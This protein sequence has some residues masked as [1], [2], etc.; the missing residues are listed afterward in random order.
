L[1]PASTT[2]AP[3]KISGWF[4]YALATLAAGVLAAGFAVV[5]RLALYHGV[6]LVTGHADILAGFSSLPVPLR[7]VLPAL[8]GLCAAALGLVAA[9]RPGGH[10]I[11]EILE[12]VAL[13]RGQIHLLTVVWKGAAS[14]VALVTGGS[15]GR[16]G[17][18]IQFGAGAGA[19]LG[20]N[21]GLADRE[22]RLL[23]A[24]GTAA[25]FAA[26]YNT[27]IAAILFVVEIVTGVLGLDVVVPAAIATAVATTL[28]RLAIGGGP[29]Y[30]QRAFALVS[31]EE[32]AAYLAVGVLAGVVGAAFMAGLSLAERFLR[33]F[34]G[35][36]LWKGALGGL[37]VGVLAIRLPQVT[38]NGYE[39]IQL[40]LDGKVASQL[41]AVLLVAKAVATI[42][43]VS[44]GSPG[45]VFT[46]SMFLGAALGGLIG[47][48]VPHVTPLH[49]SAGVAGGYALVGM[50]GIIAATTRA[51]L[52]AA[53]LGFEL[54]G[55]YSVVVPLIVAASVA[56]LVSRFLRADSVYA[57]E[58][59]RR[60]IGVTPPAPP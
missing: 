39:V 25:G 37:V 2:A 21:L 24:A 5:F 4:R 23:A 34:S 48:L 44:S 35:G 20:R 47:S 33:R 51:P 53:V 36:R 54:S 57:E 55:D 16:E 12:S 45:G 14:L 22:L 49:A 28:T 58:L 15:I 30:G 60:G 31:Q 50:S 11:A 17:S 41:L 29:L 52:M 10:G 42:A 3:A 18:I 9:R 6:R 1:E 19:M 32:L 8:G 27:P 7:V 46:P 13:G 38:G 56:A 26:A 59:R 40:I 43:S